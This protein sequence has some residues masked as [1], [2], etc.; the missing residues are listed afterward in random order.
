MTIS[1]S[2]FQPELSDQDKRPTRCPACGFDGPEAAAPTHEAGFELLTCPDCGLG[3]TWPP[4]SSEEVGK[5]Y[6]E[7]YYGKENV[8]F[9]PLFERMV[10]W[11]RKRRAS[12]LYGRVPRGP[13]AFSAGKPGPNA[14]PP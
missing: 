4:L 13:G 3:R 8:R 6:P 10:R 12:V 14:F 9:N 2:R 7:Q 11:F 5:W 1:A